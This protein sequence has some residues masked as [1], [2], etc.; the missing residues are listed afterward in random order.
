M[1]RVFNILTLIFLLLTIGMCGFVALRLSQPAVP[2]DAETAGLIPT[3]RILP[4]LTPSNTPTET[5][6]AT[7]TPT[8]TNTL[9]PTPSL[10]PTETVPPSPTITETA[11]ITFTPSDT[12]TPENSATPE[13]TATP[14]GPTNTPV[15]TT[16]PFLYDVRNGQVIFTT[17]YTNSAGCAWQGVAGQVFDISGNALNGMQVH[18]YGDTVD[19]FVV[20]GTSSL[21]GPGGWEVPVNNTIS[22]D[23][24]FVELLS[25]GG[26]VIS[27]RVQV[28]FPSDCARNLALVNFIQTRQG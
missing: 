6:P 9:S 8:P 7:F 22:A 10:T 26:T 19:Q 3:A 4:T 5:Q 12:A 25:P 15:P 17:N 14:T 21:Y 2:R 1:S 13:P 11:T 28:T 18:V 27:P 20:S 23:T 16:S 24:F